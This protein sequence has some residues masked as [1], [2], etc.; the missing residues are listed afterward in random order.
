[1]TQATTTARDLN[2][3]E[4]RAAT[5]RRSLSRRPPWYELYRELPWWANVG[6]GVAAWVVFA[7]VWQAAATL[8]WVNA[9]LVPGP[10]A[11]GVALWDLFV[12]DGFAKDVGVSLYRIA[13]SFALACAVALPVGVLMGAFRWADAALNPLIAPAR[14]LPAP[15]FIPLLLMWFGVGDGQKLALLF[16]GVIFF[17]IT[18]IADQ[19]WLVP[20]DLVEASRVLG[21]KRKGVL[22]RVVIPASLPGIVTAMRQMLAVSW[23]YLVIAEIVAT[24][25]GI[26]AMMMR[27]K[28][29]IRTDDIVAG[30]VVIGVLGLLADAMFRACHRWWFPYLYTRR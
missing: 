6:L 30:I 26:G 4:A 3:P 21:A 16:L 29:F 18:L 13:A 20:R 14:Y 11:V 8:G 2:L 17:L 12:N 15:A 7:G 27:A 10:Y 5:R 28:R 9:R 19:V 24:D 22:M 1:M 23:T 25:S